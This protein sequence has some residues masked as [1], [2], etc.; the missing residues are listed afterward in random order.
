MPYSDLRNYITRLEEEKEL[1][2]IKAEVDWNLELGAVMR[3]AND[4]REP[5]LLFGKIKYY[6]PDY[7]ILANVVGASK[8][9]A[10][11]RLCIALDLP[12]E[13]PPLEIIDELVR[14][15]TN[16]IKPVLVDKGPCKDNIIKGNDIDLFKFPVPH[17]RELDGGRFIGTWHVDINKDPDGGWVMELSRLPP[18]RVKVIA[19]G[20]EDGVFEESLLAIQSLAP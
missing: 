5:A 9:N 4:L 18:D 11:G 7:P 20:S 16:P 10:Y 1:K 12:K 15:F 2:R 14:R 13:T 3:R 17:F 6:S 8:P 19:A